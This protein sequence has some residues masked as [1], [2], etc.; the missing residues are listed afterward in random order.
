MS[1]TEALARKFP[2]TVRYKGEAYATRGNVRILRG[3]ELGVEALV[4]GTD[5][6]Q[7]RIR[8]DPN[9]ART[10]FTFNC[11]CPY[12]E[13][14]SDPCK[15]L[16]ATLRV[17]DTAGYLRALGAKVTRRTAE[18]APGARDVGDG[19]P[20]AGLAVLD[21]PGHGTAVL[22][23]DDAE[24]DGPAHAEADLLPPFVVALDAR[25]ATR[26]ANP[27]PAYRFAGAEMLFV[28]DVPGSIKGQGLALHLLVRKRAQTGEWTKPQPARLS[29]DDVA[30]APA[31]DRRIFAPLFGAA[32]ALTPAALVWP[33]P[34]RDGGQARFALPDPLVRELL[35]TIARSGRAY[36]RP[37]SSAADLHPV[38]WDEGAAWRFRLT[39]T[40][41]EDV[42]RIDGHFERGDQRLA[43]TSPLLVL[44]EGFLITR[45][46]IARWDADTETALLTTLRETGPVDV[47]LGARSA[48]AQ[49][50]ARAGVPADDL[51]EGLH[52][53]SL[54][55]SPIPRVRL[56]TLPGWPGGDRLLATV[57]FD[58]GGTIVA[59]GAAGG[60]E[61]FDPV[62]LR[63]VHRH[64]DEET[65]HLRT[66]TDLGFTTEW[67]PAGLRMRLELRVKRLAES[68]RRLVADGWVVEGEAG[69]Y[70]SAGPLLFS[71]TSGIDWFDLDARADFGG[72][73]VPLTE[74]LD[75]LRRGEGVVRLGDGGIGLLPEE[76]LRRYLPL[77]IAAEAH[78]DTLRFKPAQAA[79]LDALLPDDPAEAVVTLDEPFAQ[80]R[81][82]LGTFSE[83]AAEDPP[84]T[85]IGTLRPYQRE[86]LGWFT[87]LRR[88][89]FGGCLAD[90]MGL[91]KTVMV[92]ALLDSRRGERRPSLVVVPR[93]LVG[94]WMSEAERFAPELR[95]LDYSRTT[96]GAFRSSIADYDAVLCT[97]GTLRRD[98]E[99]LGDVEFDYL[100]L[101][102]AQAI[103]NSTTASARA[104][105]QLKG[106]HRL[107][108]SGT[109]I[110]N[111]LGELWSLFEFLNPGVLGHVVGLR[112]CDVVVEPR[113]GA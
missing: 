83:I 75:A 14:Y 86:G 93:S 95:V 74:I 101:D 28:L 46:T 52:V 21:D 45:S 91:G 72:M 89:G 8:R 92:L 58:Y 4:Q 42:F 24:E 71:V 63:I 3:N 65:A 113:A 99:M 96:R 78:G 61:V 73:T 111:H 13:K 94:N 81:R 106:R 30:Q 9:G 6:Y 85:F 20:P 25:L 84:A 100:I 66:L 50:L 2:P 37:T 82:E 112:T 70:R 53:T 39:V 98:V 47:A 27:T 41:T 76:W 80:L 29:P 103:K 19:L 51:P 67:D 90:D 102:E 107:A 64:P 109:P 32:T 12:F 69:A 77:T 31:W 40:P 68:V 7:V 5:Q 33:T 1:L 36:V 16:W 22:D 17:A 26:D 35:P 79:L 15:H 48:L 57:S 54:R 110:E 44:P 87:F 88:F 38:R 105:R 60:D 62:H 56:G 104:V 108:L 59:H 34:D 43:L 10:R 55:V 49:V 97:Y 23:I 18:V 11:S